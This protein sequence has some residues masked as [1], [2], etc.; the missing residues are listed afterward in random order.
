MSMAECEIYGKN[1][2]IENLKEVEW[3][4]EL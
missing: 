3:Y 2:P 1:Y 4:M